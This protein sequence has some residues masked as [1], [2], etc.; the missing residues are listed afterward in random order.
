MSLDAEFYAD[1][2]FLGSVKVCTN[3]A[4]RVVVMAYDKSGLKQGKR[5]MKIIFHCLLDLNDIKFT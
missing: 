1:F 2:E 5:Q 4:A 3:Y